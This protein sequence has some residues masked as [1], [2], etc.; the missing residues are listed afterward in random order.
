VGDNETGY[1]FRVGLK[2][3]MFACLIVSIDSID[4]QQLRQ[5]VVFY[6]K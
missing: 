3:F 5:M 4:V 1:A 2:K 6:E